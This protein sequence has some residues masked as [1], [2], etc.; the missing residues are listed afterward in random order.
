MPYALI[1]VLSAQLCTAFLD[2]DELSPGTPT[3]SPAQM[4]AMGIN[5][6]QPSARAIAGQRL[7]S[8]VLGPQT[9]GSS[10]SKGNPS[11]QVTASPFPFPPTTVLLVSERLKPIDNRVTCSKF[12]L[13]LYV[14]FI[15]CAYLSGGACACACGAAAHAAE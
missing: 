7:S 2:G 6:T 15:Q 1:L 9:L 4:R 8:L 5:S 10:V 12:Q 11:L 13:G 14:I 3:L